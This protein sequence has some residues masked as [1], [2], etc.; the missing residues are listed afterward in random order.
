MAQ[1]RVD[2]GF[3]FIKIYFAAQLIAIA[4]RFNQRGFAVDP[5]YSTFIDLSLF[6]FFE[7]NNTFYCHGISSFHSECSTWILKT[8]RLWT[9]PSKNYCLTASSNRQEVRAVNIVATAALAFAIAALVLPVVGL[10]RTSM[11]FV[12]IGYSALGISLG[13]QA[14]VYAGLLLF[15]SSC[16]MALKASLKASASSWLSG[17]PLVNREDR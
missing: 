13:L 3:E 15:W 9:A 6:Q 2:W 10:I 12:Y 17:E 14:V 16:C 11:I 1:N 5:H 4:H 7:E 8:Q